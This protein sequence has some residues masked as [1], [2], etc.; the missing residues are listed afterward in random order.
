[1]PLTQCLVSIPQ[2]LSKLLH[3]ALLLRD[4]LGH[5]EDLLS[6]PLVLILDLPSSVL[7]NLKLLYLHSLLFTLLFKHLALLHMLVQ[8]SQQLVGLVLLLV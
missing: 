2:P 3:V 6:H 1:M 7:F 4:V 5:A 8:V